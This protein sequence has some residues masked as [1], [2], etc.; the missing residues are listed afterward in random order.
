MDKKPRTS[1]Q[2][3]A[4][5]KRPTITEVKEMVKRTSSLKQN[6]S[7]S[8]GKDSGHRPAPAPELPSPPR[9]STGDDISMG[10]I[11]AI[12]DPALKLVFKKLV[13][14]QPADCRSASEKFNTLGEALAPE[15][16]LVIASEI[17]QWSADKQPTHFPSQ[18]TL[19]KLQGSYATA[20]QKLHGKLQR[21]RSK[22][23][24]HVLS[25][26]PDTD[27]ELSAFLE[28]CD[29]TIKHRNVE[30]ACCTSSSAGGSISRSAKDV[31]FEC[32]VV[33]NFDLFEECFKTLWSAK[34]KAVK[35]RV[36]KQRTK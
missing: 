11:D 10:D 33:E 13:C 19:K 17:L 21:R 23:E 18:R 36:D 32:M 29:V 28:H 22:G 2:R 26:V 7:T 5:Y 24:G 1:K 16:I 9:R 20:F 3:A 6:P 12:S 25:S 15:N 35:E 4:N 27:D 34:E 30:H 31:S 14:Q 8:T